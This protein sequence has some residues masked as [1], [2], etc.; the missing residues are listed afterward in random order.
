MNE[1]SIMGEICTHESD[2]EEEKEKEDNLVFNRI[3]EYEI[4][5]NFLNMGGPF[6]C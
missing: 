2:G 6:N 1:L 3:G 4:W 5:V